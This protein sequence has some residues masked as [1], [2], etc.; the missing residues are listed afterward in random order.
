MHRLV[1]LGVYLY[2]LKDC[3]RVEA[4]QSKRQ[5]HT[6][7]VIETNIP[8]ELLNLENLR[9][10]AETILTRGVDGGQNG[11]KFDVTIEYRPTGQQTKLDHLQEFPPKFGGRSPQVERPSSQFAGLPPQFGGR[12]SQPG[13]LPLEFGG[14][15]PP[16]GGL[17]R[18]FGARRPYPR[19]FTPQFGGPPREFGGPPRRFKDRR[20]GWF[21]PSDFSAFQVMEGPPGPPSEQFHFRRQ[22]HRPHHGNGNEGQRHHF[23][24]KSEGS[25]EKKNI[26]DESQISGY[27]DGDFP[28][29]LLDNENEVRR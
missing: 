12:P 7:S 10:I 2:Y 11:Q 5:I 16:P 13:G 26:E 9:S 4:S 23:S 15:P 17:P 8:L 14:R 3:S 29:I 28:V 27:I 6:E 18:Q 24:H 22:G 19:G 1:F 20:P 25:T 21:V